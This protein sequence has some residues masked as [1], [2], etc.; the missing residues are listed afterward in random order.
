M[1]AKFLE[2]EIIPWKPKGRPLQDPLMRLGLVE[3][4]ACDVPENIKIFIEN[5]QQANKEDDDK[6]FNLIDDDL[7]KAVCE[8]INAS[9]N[10]P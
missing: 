6:L 5:L 4:V 8:R 3:I 9:K 10:S 7:W 1:D 2:R